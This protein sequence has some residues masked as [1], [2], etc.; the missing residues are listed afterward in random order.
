[1]RAH[2]GVYIIVLLLTLCCNMD[3]A[4]GQ[5]TGNALQKEIP[6]LCYHQVRNREAKDKASGM[7]YIIPVEHFKAHMKMLHDSGYHAILPDALIAYLQKGAPLPEKPVLLTFDDGTISQYTNALPVLNQY[8]FKGVFFIMTVTLDKLGYLSRSQV[9]ELSDKGHVIGC[10]TWD[11]HKVT[12]YRDSDWD[13]QLVKPT[14]LLE[15]ITGKPVVYFAY[16]FGIWDAHAVGKLKAHHY[17]GAFQLYGKFD[18]A[19]MPF[20][21]RRIIAD[22]NWSAGQLLNAIK[23][24]FR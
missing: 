24:N 8:G 14:L 12:E 17:K 1:M 9:K 23:R 19:A 20:A 22:G 16:P 4:K 15:S 18:S 3:I 13:L 21:I 10:H 2:A 11:H 7:P 5:Q 6:V